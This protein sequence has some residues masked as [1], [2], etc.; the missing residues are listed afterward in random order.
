MRGAGNVSIKYTE[1]LFE[2]F[3]IYNIKV[4]SGNE[5]IRERIITL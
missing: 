5:Q 3:Y 4:Y 1:V 2:L